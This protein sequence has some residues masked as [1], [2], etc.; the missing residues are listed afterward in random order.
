MASES[1]VK[2]DVPMPAGVDELKKSA[3]L[4]V[5][6]AREFNVA[7][8]DDYRVA[9]NELK[10]IKQRR[11]ALDAARK[12]ITRPLD[13]AKARVMDLFKPVIALLDEAETL[14]KRT[15][16]AYSDEQARIQREQQAKLEEE[17]RKER[18]RLA[19]EAEKA[20]AKGRTERAEE[21]Q[22][23]AA[24]TVAPVVAAAAPTAAGVHERT[25]WKCRE[26]V[27]VVE[28]CRA[29]AEGKVAPLAVLPNMKFLNEQARSLEDH[30]NI[31]GCK[32][33]PDKG[34][35]ASKRG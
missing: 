26:E 27:D 31:P 13:E 6:L 32:A 25:V 16:L 23:R 19:R 11:D 12:Q 17:A 3:P 9:A 24:A 5:R 29:V 10:K 35:S 15:M 33:Y 14:Y 34:L 21:L 1:A 4:I 20:A 2:L 22:Q 30:F 28:L 18:E 8:L 7:S